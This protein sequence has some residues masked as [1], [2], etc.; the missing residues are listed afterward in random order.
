[1]KP[2]LVIEI[3]EIVPNS[4]MTTA[5]QMA[6]MVKYWII[7]IVWKSREFNRIVGGLLWNCCVCVYTN[8]CVFFYLLLNTQAHSEFGQ[9]FKLMMMTSEREMIIAVLNFRWLVDV[10][11]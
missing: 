1:M 9:K 3:V 2:K 5:I 11:E 4:W 7:E 8:M 10:V 6:K